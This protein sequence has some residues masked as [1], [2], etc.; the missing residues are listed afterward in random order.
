[1]YQKG[2]ERRL[3]R[4]QLVDIASGNATNVKVRTS[5]TVRAAQHAARVG[6]ARKKERHGAAAQPPHCAR[7]AAPSD[8]SILRGGPRPRCGRRFAINAALA[9]GRA[10]EQSV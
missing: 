4:Q 9:A 3:R 10:Q 8:A 5:S 6:R 1:M 7:N 2:M